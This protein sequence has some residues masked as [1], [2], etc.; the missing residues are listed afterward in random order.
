MLPVLAVVVGVVM[1]EAAA[2]FMSTA[3]CTGRSAAKG[4]KKP[5]KPRKPKPEFD[6]SG[7]QCGG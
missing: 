4:E 5:H 7:V 1:F 2:V 3:L 6:F